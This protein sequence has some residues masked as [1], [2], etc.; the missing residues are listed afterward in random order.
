LHARHPARTRAA[1]EREEIVLHRTSN[2]FVVVRKFGSLARPIATANVKP[3]ASPPPAASPW[4]L[5]GPA[6]SGAKSRPGW[7][8]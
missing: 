1:R 2:G 6:T 8:D 3:S 5:T 4:Y 7:S